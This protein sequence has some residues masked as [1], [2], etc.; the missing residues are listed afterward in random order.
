MAVAGDAVYIR[1]Y[2]YPDGS[3]VTLRALP[4]FRLEKFH[5]LRSMGQRYENITLVPLLYSATKV[6]I[7]SISCFHVSDSLPK[8]EFSCF[9]M[10]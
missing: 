5:E 4:I 3:G 8:Y 1:D 9:C 2:H 6:R 7:M 10:S